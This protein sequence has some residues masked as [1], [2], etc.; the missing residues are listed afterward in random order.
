MRRDGR[1]VNQTVLAMPG[2]PGE[3]VNIS[4]S[5]S[6]VDRDAGFHIVCSNA[7]DNMGLV[8]VFLNKSLLKQELCFLQKIMYLSKKSLH[9]QY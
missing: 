3:T 7:V 5:W 6:P 9:I 8:F 4:M 1:P 2:T